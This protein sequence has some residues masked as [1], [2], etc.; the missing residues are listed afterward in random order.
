MDREKFMTTEM[1]KVYEA[2]KNGTR[3][4]NNILITYKD[5]ATKTGLQITMVSSCIRFLVRD[6]YIEKE[7]HLGLHGEAKSNSYKILKVI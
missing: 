3:K 1:K 4:G 2:I 6:K 5:I 7:N